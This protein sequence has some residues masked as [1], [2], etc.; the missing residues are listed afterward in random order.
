MSH[1]SS[2]VLVDDHP[3][4]RQGIAGL[5]KAEPD[6]TVVGEANGP[7]EAIPMCVREQPDLAIIDL[8]L[9]E[10][11]GLDLIR[12]LR[13]ALPGLRVLV[14][15]MHDERIW[16]ERC[17]RAGA[18]GYLMKEVAA[19]QVVVAVRNVLKGER[20]LSR[21][22]LAALVERAVGGGAPGGAVS[23]LSD[24]ELEVFRSIGEGAT[25]RVIAERLSVSVKT[26]EA[27]KANIKRKLG[28]ADAG[29]LA[30][31]AMEWAAMGSEVK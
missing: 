22:L 4:I 29:E 16:A 1:P 7:A 8:S 31:L 30:R 26:I 28:A 3:L 5:L 10:G 12:Q 13:H 9:R 15:S 6:L 18:Q 14:V 24:R 11:S 23:S 20:W 17:L 21:N 27:H 2:I 25:T 19:D